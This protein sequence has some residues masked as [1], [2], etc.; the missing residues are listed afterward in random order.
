MTTPDISGMAFQWKRQ[1]IGR[2]EELIRYTTLAS[3]SKA[4]TLYGQIICFKKSTNYLTSHHL[5]DSYFSRRGKTF[6]LTC[7]PE[8][9]G[10]KAYVY[11]C[12]NQNR[13]SVLRCSLSSLFRNLIPRTSVN[14][15]WQFRRIVLSF[16]CPL[17]FDVIDYIVCVWV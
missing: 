10:Q 9:S 13:F 16:F 6:W 8:S 15:D 11:I 14:D 1:V 12:F 3:L 5:Q 4:L 7:V 17:L 2:R